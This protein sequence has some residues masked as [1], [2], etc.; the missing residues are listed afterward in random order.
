MAA[1][2]GKHTGIT[3]NHLKGCATR[4][5]GAS[6]T[7]WPTYRARCRSRRS[8]GRI[9]WSSASRA[10]G[11]MAWSSAAPGTPFLPKTPNDR[12]QRAW[13]AAGLR[14]I[15][16]HECRHTFASFTVSDRATVRDRIQMK[17]KSGQALG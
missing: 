8:C 17:S 13:R 11:A 1:R 6:C 14:P 4:T 10:R 5:G 3:V 7:C 16:L 12:A 15:G 9:C 2:R